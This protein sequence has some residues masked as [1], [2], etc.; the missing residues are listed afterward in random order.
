MKRDRRRR[1]RSLAPRFGERRRRRSS[2]P[3]SWYDPD[4]EKTCE[5]DPDEVGTT[6]I[7]S[8]TRY[9]DFGYYR[10]ECGHPDC[11]ETWDW[12]IEG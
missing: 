9:S 1:R 8:A 5:H 11:E 3:P 4:N 2:S 10:S 6:R 12:W 7:A